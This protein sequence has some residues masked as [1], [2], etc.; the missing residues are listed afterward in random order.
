[1]VSRTPARRGPAAPSLCPGRSARDGC[2]ADRRFGVSRQ[3]DE[4]PLHLEIRREPALP[5]ERAV[6][7]GQSNDTRSEL[8]AGHALGL[9]V[10]LLGAKRVQPEPLG[11]LLR[12]YPAVAQ[13]LDRPEAAD[14]APEGSGETCGRVAAGLR[15]EL[16]DRL[17]DGKRPRY[18]SSR[19]GI[20]ERV[21]GLVGGRRRHLLD[22]PSAD[23]LSGGP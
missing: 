16:E 18:V 13:P 21:R 5:L 6:E 22:L 20:R 12:G 19:P 10:E 9:R 15:A 8:V 3:V 2:P 14:M 17:A 4:G 1:M 7:L 23:R 11:G